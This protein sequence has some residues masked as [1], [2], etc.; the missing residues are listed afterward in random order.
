MPLPQLL[1]DLTLYIGLGVDVLLEQQERPGV[2]PVDWSTFSEV[3]IVCTAIG[4]SKSSSSSAQ[5]EIVNGNRDLRLHVLMADTT[6]KSEAI[7]TYQVQARSGATEWRDISGQGQLRM[8]TP[9]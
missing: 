4:L 8:R 5:L 1:P 6:G 2:A 7:T 9:G 3:R